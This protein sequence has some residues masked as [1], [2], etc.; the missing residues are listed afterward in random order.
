MKTISQKSL[1][2]TINL[3]VPETAEE[4][5][6]LAGE[7]NACVEDAVNQIVMHKTLSKFRDKFAEALEKSLTVDGVCSI[8]WPEDKEATAKATPKKDGTVTAVHI[9]PK[10]YFKLVQAKEGKPASAYQHL[11]DTVSA[12]L[13][14]DPS[15][16]ERAGGRVSKANTAAAESLLK[17]SDRT[18]R[19]IST[20]EARNVGL[21][22]EVDA[23]GLPT[24]DELARAI[25]VDKARAAKELIDSLGA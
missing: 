12:S 21:K 24:A 2:L 1:D 10:D 16:S 18:R 22:V 15:E 13:T 11:A 20:L 23:E 7:T 9:T 25:A 17:D 5:D 4:Y 14:F 3:S 19:A 8:P 6:K